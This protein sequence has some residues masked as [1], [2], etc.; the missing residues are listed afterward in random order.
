VI[1]PEYS[2]IYIQNLSHKAARNIIL[3]F[4]DSIVRRLAK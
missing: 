3:R 2:S 1:E 4:V